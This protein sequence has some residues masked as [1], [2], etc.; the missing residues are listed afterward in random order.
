MEASDVFKALGVRRMCHLDILWILYLRPEMNMRCPVDDG[1]VQGFPDP[2]KP[3]VFTLL[4]SR[5]REVS[6]SGARLCLMF[7][8]GHVQLP[9][10]A[11]A[12]PSMTKECSLLNYLRYNDINILKSNYF[13]KP[14]VDVA[15]SKGGSMSSPSSP[16]SSI[17]LSLKYDYSFC[18]AA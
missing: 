13:C 2:N 15:H 5:H 12:H 11:L 3:Y 4:R 7:L 9:R 18:M 17:D 16:D 8:L 1:I 6:V 14:I 10:I